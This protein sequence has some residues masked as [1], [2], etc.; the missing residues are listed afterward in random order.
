MFMRV[1]ELLGQLECL[2]VG[3]A[4][5]VTVLDILWLWQ[6]A[7]AS[8]SS[9]RLRGF[10]LVKTD[11]ELALLETFRSD[12]NKNEAVLVIQTAEMDTGDLDRMLAGMSLHEIMKN[13]IYSTFQGDVSRDVKPYK[14]WAE[15]NQGNT[16]KYNVLW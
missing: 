15:K 6:Q 7:G 5:V 10:N 3:V 8:T 1:M 4:L 16:S 12:N 9:K 2:E 14:V 13:D 11:T